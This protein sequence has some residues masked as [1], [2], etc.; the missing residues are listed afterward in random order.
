M[1]H[2]RKSDDSLGECDS[3]EVNSIDVNGNTFTI[4]L[5]QYGWDEYDY[6]YEE[7][8]DIIEIRIE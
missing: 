1:I 6:W 2:Y 4:T 3:N 7:I 8:N 5:I